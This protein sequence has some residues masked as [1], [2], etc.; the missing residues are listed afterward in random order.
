MASTALAL[1]P[2]LIDD[3]GEA[4]LGGNALAQ[5]LDQHALFDGLH[6]AGFQVEQLEGAEGDTDQAVD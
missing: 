1:A 6:L 2:C 4:K 3:L 5:L